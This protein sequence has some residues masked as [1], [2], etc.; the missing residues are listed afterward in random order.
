[1]VQEW[2][3]IHDATEQNILEYKESEEKEED[4]QFVDFV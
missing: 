2:N 1:M 4:I 3:K